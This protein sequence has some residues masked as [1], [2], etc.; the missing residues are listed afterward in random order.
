MSIDELSLE[1]ENAFV[2]A[3][4]RAERRER[5]MSKLNHAKHRAGFL[6]RL[7]H[8]F[9]VDIDPRFI[10]EAPQLH[11]PL[12]ATSCYI[13]ASQNQL[14]RRLV[15]PAIAQEFLDA[16]TFGIL[17]SYLPGRLAAYKDESPSDVIW[18]ERC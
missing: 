1:H 6:D 9:L 10:V 8:R 15:A 18:L 3:F 11:D 5:Y 17:V 12:S 16:A 13:M 7:N 14:D 2:M 4:I